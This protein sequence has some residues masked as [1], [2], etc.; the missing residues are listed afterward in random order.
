[1]LSA[2]LQPFYVGFSLL[3]FEKHQDHVSSY[4]NH[5]EKCWLTFYNMSLKFTNEPRN[6]KIA[7]LTL[8][9]YACWWPGTIRSQDIFRHRDDQVK[10]QHVLSAG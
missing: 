7:Y 1:M 3:I 10:V 2:K 5:F 4:Q 8:C 6:L 9:S